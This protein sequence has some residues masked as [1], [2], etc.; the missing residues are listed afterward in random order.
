MCSLNENKPLLYSILSSFGLVILLVT[1]VVPD[2][3]HQFSVV[4]FP[5]EVKLIF[6]NFV[7]INAVFWISVSVNTFHNAEW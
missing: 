1:G 6:H 4:E 7:V 2:I 5:E 3:A